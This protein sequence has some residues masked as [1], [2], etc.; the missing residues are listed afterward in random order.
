M[1]QI[2][3]LVSIDIRQIGKYAEVNIEKMPFSLMVFDSQN[4]FGAALEGFRVRELAV[5][6]GSGNPAR[7]G[8]NAG[9]ISAK[10]GRRAANPEEAAFSRANPQSDQN[11]QVA[12]PILWLSI[13]LV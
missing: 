11:C 6:L 10:R 9:T 4:I 2:F 1:Y 13:D 3:W 12:R 5:A 7:A 8:Q